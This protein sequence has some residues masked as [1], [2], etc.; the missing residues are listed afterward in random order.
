LRVNKPAPRHLDQIEPVQQCG[1]EQSG[2]ATQIDRN[3]GFQR[4]RSQTRLT[5]PAR[6]IKGEWHLRHAIVDATDLIADNKA[7]FDD[8]KRRLIAVTKGG[9]RGVSHFRKPWHGMTAQA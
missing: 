4:L 5:L 3:L 9:E 2:L 6:Q 1:F 7:R 8:P